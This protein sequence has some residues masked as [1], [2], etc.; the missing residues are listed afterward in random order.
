MRI[1]RKLLVP[2]LIFI[3]LVIAGLLSYNTVVSVQKFD[4]AEQQRLGDMSNVFQARLNAKE[5]LAVALASEVANNPEVQAAFAAGDRE[6]LIE[7]TLHF[8]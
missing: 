4:A 5:D 6:R 1:T 8:S 7:L 2:T 3:G